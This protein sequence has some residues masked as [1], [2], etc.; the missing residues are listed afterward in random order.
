MM[1]RDGLSATTPAWL[2]TRGYIGAI[3]RTLS[4]T[5]MQIANL[6]PL[7][8]A[9][10]GR[11]HSARYRLREVTSQAPW[12]T[13]LIVNLRTTLETYLVGTAV[14]NHL[15]NSLAPATYVK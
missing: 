12:R 9:P 7:S 6:L 8:Q 15:N 3:R 4:T 10:P 11:P 1:E 5:S 2:Y 14:L 13:T